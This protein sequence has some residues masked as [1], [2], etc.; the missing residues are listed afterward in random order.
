MLQYLESRG[1]P[2]A[3]ATRTCGIPPL[4]GADPDHRVTGKQ[5]EQLWAFAAER[6]ADP[7]IGL[8]MAE[9]YSPGAL[10]I[11]GYV[12]LSCATIGEVLDRLARYAPI[13]N[14]GMRIE[15][16]RKTELPFAGAASSSRWTT[17]YCG[18]LSRRSVRR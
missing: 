18:I 5:V 1:I 10:D 2:T 17:I 16:V 12:I 6:A 8:H 13:L 3:V 11:L 14:D 9:A 4:V 15:V 7:L